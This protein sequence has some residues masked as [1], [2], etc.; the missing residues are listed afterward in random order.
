[1]VRDSMLKT[2]NASTVLPANVNSIL[3]ANANMN[4][5]LHPDANFNSVL[6]AAAKANA[7]IDEQS[8]NSF[9]DEPEDSEA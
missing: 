2:G 6:P 4:S 3:P 5:L 1:M 9:F 7:N 8:E